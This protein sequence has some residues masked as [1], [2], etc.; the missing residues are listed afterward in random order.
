MEKRRVVITGFGAIT[1]LGNDAET[2]WNNLLVGKSGIT[3]ITK[4]DTTGFSVRIAGEVKNFDPAK[5]IPDRREAKRLDP[6]A[7]YAVAASDM[8]LESAA[9]D[10]SKENRDRVG[11]VIGSGIG[12]I[13]EFEQ[14]HTR[15]IERGPMKISPFFILKLMLN[16]A[17]GQLGVRY[18]IRGPNFA[19]AS[20]CASSGHSLGLA[21]RCIQC[22]DCDI[23]IAGGSEA[24]MTQLGISGFQVM[25]A[26]STRNDEPEKASRPFD[27]GRDGF[28]LS[29]GAGTLILEELEHAKKRGARIYAEFTSCGMSDDGYH[30]TAPDPNGT[31]AQRCM[32]YAVKMAGRK[33]EDVDYINAHGTSTPHNDAAETRAV[34]ALFGEHA[35][36]LAISSSK[37]MLG[38][39]LGASG[40]VELII[41]ALSIYH[42]KVPPTTN[43]ENP[44]DGCDLDYVADGARDMKI[45]FALSNSFGFGGHNVSLS[46]ARY[47]E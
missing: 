44:E 37:S 36:K 30:I 32:E 40:A 41:T 4:F 38:H 21:L 10:L 2:M 7:Q 26:L 5:W 20:A 27:K 23:M 46:L 28:V 22:G 15:Y 6:F 3:G 31:G 33:L 19:T 35:K 1:P 47:E 14:Q 25:T 34:K 42:Q 9:L 43:L 11:A 17:S 16:A 45:D 29:E 13:I 18:G 8:A 24:A 12:G 39:L